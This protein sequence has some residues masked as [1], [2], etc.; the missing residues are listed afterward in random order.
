MT[1]Q[2]HK[3]LGEIIF[4]QGLDI[5]NYG[6]TGGRLMQLLKHFFIK[7]PSLARDVT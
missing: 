1:D 7:P 2:R 6:K 5:P 4:I 3:S